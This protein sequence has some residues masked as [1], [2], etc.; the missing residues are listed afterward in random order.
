MLHVSVCSSSF[1]VRSVILCSSVA[2]P[3][4]PVLVVVEC[5]SVGSHTCRAA[6]VTCHQVVGA[7]EEEACIAAFLTSGQ[8]QVDMEVCS[9]SGIEC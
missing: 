3:L 5:G 1:A 7:G 8:D 4:V 2:A 9:G 6:S